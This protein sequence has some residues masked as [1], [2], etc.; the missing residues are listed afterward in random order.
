MW[1]LHYRL[2]QLVCLPKLVVDFYFFLLL[3]HRKH[4]VVLSRMQATSPHS[5][6]ELSYWN[7]D[8]CKFESS[9]KYE[10]RAQSADSSKAFSKPR[11]L[12]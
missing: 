11:A 12:N 7:T 6:V 8:M 10:S 9:Q 4:I 1:H 5:P 2:T 3:R